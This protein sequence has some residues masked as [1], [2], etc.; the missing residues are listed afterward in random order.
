MTRDVTFYTT[1]A[2]CEKWLLTAGGLSRILELS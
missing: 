2:G 1:G